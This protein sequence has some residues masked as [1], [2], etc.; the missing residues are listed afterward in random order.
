MLQPE[1]TE[2]TRELG[3]EPDE[4]LD[5]WKE[6]AAFLGRGVRTVQRWEEVER[7]PVHRHVHSHGGTVFAYKS[8]LRTWSSQRQTVAVAEQ[9]PATVETRFV[10]VAGSKPPRSRQ[11]VLIAG[12]IAAIVI[13]ASTAVFAL[14]FERQPAGSVPSVV[15]SQ[16]GRISQTISSP[17]GERFVYCWN[18][19]REGD[20]LDLYLREIK[21]GVNRRLTSHPNNDHS[22]AWSPAGDRIAFLRDKIGV[23]VMRLDGPGEQ[24]ME[25]ARPDS[26]YGVGMSW[27][28]D[29]RWLVF[30]ERQPSTANPTLVALD[31]TTRERRRVT[32]ASDSNAED[33]YPSFS[34]DGNRIAFVRTWPGKSSIGLLHFAAN[35]S[36][37]PVSFVHESDR[38]SIAGLDWLPNGKGIVYSS[39]RE[40]LRRLWRIRSGLRNKRWLAAEPLPGSDDGWQ[41][42]AARHA[43][44]IVFSR[45]F[46]NSSIWRTT[47]AADAS[48]P[49]AFDRL[50]GSTR[51]DRSPA[52]SPDGRR[53]AFVSNRSGSSEIWTSDSEGHN[54]TQWTHSRFLQPEHPVWS[55]DSCR[56]AFSLRS[57]AGEG[58]YILDSADDSQRRLTS[59]AVQCNSPSWSRDGRYLYCSAIGVETVWRVPLS[60]GPATQVVA[61]FRPQESPDAAW[62]YFIRKGA[63]WRIPPSGGSE[64]KL[65]DAPVGD[66]AVTHRGAYFDLGSGDYVQGIIKFFDAS[67]HKVSVVTQLERRKS[68][69]LAI[70]PDDRILLFPVNERQGSEVL[71]FK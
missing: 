39:D 47:I 48:S 71:V 19:D 42:S 37:S 58:I 61:G 33:L 64:E 1:S 46:W 63:L 52:W 34:P 38:Q 44:S 3:D 55:P 5:S 2:K 15:V 60:G 68:G 14:I 51:I 24:Q 70:S 30:S 35:G 31:L 40:G 26:M 13:L 7:L 49:P 12:L 66:F 56:I 27:S 8:E 11:K 43:D 23:F 57:A 9:L 17:D 65:I 69:G 18:G 36:F 41:P 16:I 10:E 22:A 59:D 53:I 21:T 50:I 62:L 32:S 6:I 4:R 28:P 45:R 29:G 20:N 54:E 25:A 67:S